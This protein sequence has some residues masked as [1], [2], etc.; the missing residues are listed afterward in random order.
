MK[1]HRFAGAIALALLIAPTPAP[2]ITSWDAAEGLGSII[3]SEQACGLSL[4]GRAVTGWIEANVDRKDMKFTE[5]LAL[6]VRVKSR[7]LAEMSQ[8]MKEA[9]CAQV[10][11][12]V[13]AYAIGK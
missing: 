4:D 13:K 2:A 7:E 11:R 12:L 1:Q 10:G 3:A 6:H 5:T 9:H 8:T